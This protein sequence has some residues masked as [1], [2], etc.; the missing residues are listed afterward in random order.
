MYPKTLTLTERLSL[1]NQFRILSKLENDSEYYA[2]KAEI[3]ENGL[4]GLYGKVFNELS[5]EIDNKTCD[6]THSI[7]Q[8]FMNISNALLEL[9]EEE[10]NS[11]NIEKLTFQGF[12]ANNDKHYSYAHFMI[13]KL[14]RYEHY[15]EFKK[16]SHTTASIGIY[17]KMIKVYNQIISKDK[18][19]I[20]LTFEDLKALSSS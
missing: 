9:K 7:F 18:I 6:E 2:L 1:A 4:T 17:R 12:D 5:E 19:R 11:L 15:E 14:G 13:D 8:M 16:N 20:E 3:L 10:K